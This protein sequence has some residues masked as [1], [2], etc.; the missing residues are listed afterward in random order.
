MNKIERSR[1]LLSLI[2]KYDEAYFTQ[3]KSLISDEEYD[4]LYFELDEYLKDEEVQKA[5]GKTD[6]PL[7]Q[8]KSHLD[9]VSHIFPVLSL[10]KQK[11]DDPKFI[12]KLKQ[13]IKKYD[14]GQGFVIQSKL[15]GLTIVNYK[16]KN[17]STFATRGQGDKGENVT[18][19]L[20]YD[21]KLEV[22]IKNTPSSM[23]IKGEGIISN[24]K[25]NEIVS[26]QENSIDLIIKALSSYV[27][28]EDLTTIL[29][30]RDDPKS[31]KSDLNEL[32]KTSDKSL[33]DLLKKYTDEIDGQYSS[34]RNLASATL[35]QKDINAA[36]KYEAKVLMYDIL[37]SDKFNLLTEIDCVNT[38][39][40]YGYETV[41]T[42]HFSNEELLEFFKDESKAEKWRHEED[43]PIDGLV[44]KPN[45]KIV[46]P[47]VTGH[48]Q[49]GQL[50]I[51]F[52]PAS[53]DSVLRDVVWTYGK[54]GRMTPKA[55]FDEVI[56]TG[57]RITK[58][59][60]AS[61]SKIEE[62]GIKIGS[63]IKVVKANDVIPDIKHVYTERENGSEKEIP[64]PKNAEFKLNEKGELGKV[65]YAKDYQLPLEDQLENFA[66]VVKI[67]A[68]KK[69]T[70]KKLVDNGFI[71]NFE[72]LYK[73]KDKKEELY[74]IPGLGKTS[75]D[76]MLEQIE[77]SKSASFDKIVLGL[78]INNLGKLASSTLYKYAK[79]VNE[80]INLS[81]DF[82]SSLSD[83]GLNYLAVDAIKDLKNDPIKLVSLKNVGVNI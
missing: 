47:E 57:S 74:E 37:N 82:I 25:F 10:D 43:Y 71:I 62:L 77:L 52:A 16:S 24:K 46:N 55:I 78:G 63:H 58:A 12:H 28:Q 56:I 27:N 61:W 53:A 59:S 1:E 19:Q 44:I 75:I 45:L 79:N 83:E 36:S 76:K 30:Y 81:D 26:E 42:E 5:L 29:N 35:R 38:L 64:F 14:T 40:Q 3:N 6:M 13:F 7:G 31:Y 50:A 73:L 51:K 72:D 9:K 21:N 8:Q 70:F 20:T 49:K 41:K 4:K 17:D 23:V 66:K 22:A 67:D 2:N 54:E 69:A 32:K 34:A 11:I 33:K 68:A 65:L 80:F 18:A 15:D 60:L 39:T 48:H